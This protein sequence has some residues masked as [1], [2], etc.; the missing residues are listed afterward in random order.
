MKRVI[1]TI[2]AWF[3]N[4]FKSDIVLQHSKGETVANSPVYAFIAE[5]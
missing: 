2:L 1:F 3:R 4:Y 5:L